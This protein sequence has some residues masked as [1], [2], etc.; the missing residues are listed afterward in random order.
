MNDAKELRGALAEFR[1]FD[2]V[3]M[4]TAGSS[5]FNL[6]QIN[7]L[8]AMLQAARPDE[9]F[10][11]MSASTQLDDLRNV[12]ANY[13]CVNPTSALFSKLD[14]TRQ[15]GAMFSMLVEAGLPLSYLSVGQNVPDDFRVAAP[16]MLANLI[17]GGSEHRG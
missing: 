10:L 5:Q 16:N 4:D 13:R 2:L 7:E 17:M 15:Y 1:D 3:L 14:E 11:V 8:K 6:E 9:I 12:A